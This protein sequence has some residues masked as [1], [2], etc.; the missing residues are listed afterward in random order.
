MLS[1]VFWSGFGSS[2]V[3]L[4][5]A[6]W[7]SVNMVLIVPSTR[8]LVAVTRRALT[9]A[10]CRRPPVPANVGSMALLFPRFTASTPDNHFTYHHS[11]ILSTYA[12]GLEIPSLRGQEAPA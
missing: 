9:T 10:L 4:Q 12:T 1:G 8:F 5:M 11:I 6:V 7:A 2:E 3:I